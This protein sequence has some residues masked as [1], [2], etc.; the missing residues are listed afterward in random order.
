MPKRVHTPTTPDQLLIAEAARVA[1]KGS[2][3][4]L[5]ELVGTKSKSTLAHVMAGTTDELDPVVRRQLEH[6]IVR[7][8]VVAGIGAPVRPGL[9]NHEWADRV[10]R[11]LLSCHDCLHAALLNADAHEKEATRRRV[12]ERKAKGASARA[13]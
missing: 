10:L 13:R 3:R 7:G 1:A 8:Q 12:A 9:T 2:V 11:H 6:L 5:G 4:R